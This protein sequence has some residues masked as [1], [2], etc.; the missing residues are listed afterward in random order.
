MINASVEKAALA[1]ISYSV[2]IDNLCHSY[3]CRVRVGR[4]SSSITTQVHWG[5]GPR[6]GGIIVD[7]QLDWGSGRSANFTEPDEATTAGLRQP[8]AAAVH[9]ETRVQICGMGPARR[10]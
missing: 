3:L 2:M 9:S 4:T 5:A 6:L 8:G 7:R 10:R 1:G